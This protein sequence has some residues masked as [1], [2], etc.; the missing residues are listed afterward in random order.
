VRI[1]VEGKIILRENDCRGHSVKRDEDLR[2]K[3][4]KSHVSRHDSTE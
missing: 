4:V 3:Y 1:K 2:E